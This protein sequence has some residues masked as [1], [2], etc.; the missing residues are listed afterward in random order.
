M[1]ELRQLVDVWDVCM[2]MFCVFLHGGSVQLGVL[3]GIQL[4]FLTD[5]IMHKQTQN[6]Y[7][8]QIVP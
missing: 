2:C 1:S 4:A 6:L 8:T 3:F 5:E 7:Y